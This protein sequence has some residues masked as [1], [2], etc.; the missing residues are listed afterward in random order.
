MLITEIWPHTSSHQDES[1]SCTNSFKAL[2]DEPSSLK[3][4]SAFSFKPLALC[5]ISTPSLSTISLL[6]PFSIFPLSKT[7]SIS[8]PIFHTRHTYLELKSWSPK[9]GRHSIGTPSQTLSRVEFQPQWLQNP[10]TAPCAN[11]S[12]CGAH[13]TMQPLPSVGI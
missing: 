2:Q 9:N 12:F 10:P 11:T 3:Q 8:K 7:P 5:L 1:I 6:I 13:F 4:K